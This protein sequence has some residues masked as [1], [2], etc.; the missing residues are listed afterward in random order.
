MLVAKSSAKMEQQQVSSLSPTSSSMEQTGATKTY[1]R[2]R[3]APRIYN[4]DKQREYYNRFKSNRGVKLFETVDIGPVKNIISFKDRHGMR[5]FPMHQ[6][7]MTICDKRFRQTG[8]KDMIYGDN[9]KNFEEIELPPLPNEEYI[10]ATGEKIV[11]TY[12]LYKGVKGNTKFIDE[13]GF[14]FVVIHF[15]KDPAIKEFFVNLTDDTPLKNI[16]K[17]SVTPIPQ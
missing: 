2:K 13:N 12:A 14:T 3:Y 6:L 8:K 7:L 15:T 5:W 16:I 4:K 10:S 17:L 11:K 9:M 1:K